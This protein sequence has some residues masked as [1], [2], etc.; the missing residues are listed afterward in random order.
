MGRLYRRQG[1]E[2]QQHLMSGMTRRG[3][4]HRHEPTSRFSIDRICPITVY[5]SNYTKGTRIIVM[6]TL[7]VDKYALVKVGFSM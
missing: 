5:H 3:R 7:A 4:R 6:I 1:L 2:K